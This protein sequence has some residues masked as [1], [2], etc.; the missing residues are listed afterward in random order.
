MR[1]LNFIALISILCL[2]GPA[3]FAEEPVD[4][5]AVTK[6]RDQGFRHSQVMDLVWHLTEGVGP[7][8]TGS[9][10]GLNAHRW[11]ETTLEKWGLNSWLESF[12]FGRG[13]TME[14]VQVRMTEP[15]IQPLEA[16]PGAWSPGTEGPVQGKVVRATLESDDDLEEWRGKLG[17]T[18]VLLEDAVKPEQIDA[19]LFRR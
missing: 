4:L 2:L 15:Y 12:D 10:Q 11:A 18:I 3:V 7:R 19:E 8:L 6:I 14:R 16:L 5:A 17:G 1:R 9:P 13:W